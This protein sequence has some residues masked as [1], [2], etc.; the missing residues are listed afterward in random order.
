MEEQFNRIID[1]LEMLLN[2]NSDKLAFYSIII[3][4]L[5]LIATIV[6]NIITHRQYI[7]SLD[8]LLSFEFYDNNGFLLLSVENTGKSVADN[9]LI[10]IDGIS[11]NGEKNELHLDEVFGNKFTLFPNEKIQ[12]V[13]ALFGKDISNNI[14][15]VLKAK[16]SYVKGNTKKVEKYERTI[17]FTKNIQEKINLRGLENELHSLALSTVRLANY[18]EGRFLTS[19]DDRNVSPQSTLYRDLRDILNKKDRKDNFLVEELDRDL[20]NTEKIVKK[21]LKKEQK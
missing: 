21:N 8:P 11:N 17:T 9:V 4:I 13:V 14:F 6:Y 12:G 1:L 7:N 2:S 3:A 20:E 18:I 5:A 15:P 19:F 10:E 16:I